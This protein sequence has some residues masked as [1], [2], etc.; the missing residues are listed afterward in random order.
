[1]VARVPSYRTSETALGDRAL[2]RVADGA[3]FR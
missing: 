3:R 1:M 2:A